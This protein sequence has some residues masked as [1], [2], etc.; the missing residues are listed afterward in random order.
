MAL[1]LSVCWAAADQQKPVSTVPHLE[2]RG[3]AT[4]LIV[5]GNAFLVLAGELYNNSATSLDYMK[6]IWPRLK[7]MHLNTVLAPVSWALLEP[8]EGKF[9]F[10]LVDGLIRDARAHDLHLV[11]LWFGSWKN[12][13]SSYTPDWVKRDFERFPRV[14][15][16]NGSGTERLSPLSAENRDADAHAFSALMRRIRQVDGDAHTVLMMQVENEVGVIPDARDHSPAADSAYSA[17]VPHELISY[18]ERHK[19]SLDPELRARWQATDF[20]TSG[21]WEAV[22]GP[23]LETEDLFMAWQY[24]RYIGKV[25]EAGKAEYDLPMFANAALIR[26]SYAPG[27]YNS[28]GPLPH[29]MDI[30]KAGAPQLDFLAPDIYF[31]FKKWC[32]AYAR[33]GNPFFIPET[34]GGDQ[35][36]ANIFYALG[37]HHAM[38]FSPFGIDNSSEYGPDHELARSYDIL[39]QLAPRILEC[40]AKNCAAGVVLEELTPSQRVRVGNYTLNVSRSGRRLP[41]E[42]PVSAQTRPPQT[43]HGIFI[44]TAPDEFYLAGNGLTITFSADAPGPPLVGLATVEEGE[45]REGRWAHGRTLGGDD[46]GQGNSI[47]LRDD[48]SSGILHVTVYRYR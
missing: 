6:P 43:P 3:N 30:W 12:T 45:F 21:N 10:T 35:G 32:A 9:D 20:K 44:E 25:A 34:V 8:S 17:P 47:S 27:Q 15:L 4:Q 23:G 7:A 38:G 42:V 19:D 16:R 39:S 33:P 13:W 5:D 31:E 48:E 36:A 1:S 11:F 14:Q 29:S 18:L 24:A 22:F 40:Q 26:P 28:G 46:T 41:L 2:R 37:Q